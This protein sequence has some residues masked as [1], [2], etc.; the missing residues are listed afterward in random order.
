MFIICF[1]LT[2]FAGMLVYKFGKNMK[3]DFLKAYKIE[4]RENLDNSNYSFYTDVSFMSTQ[5]THR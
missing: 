4:K 3:F 2:L 5:S 1:V